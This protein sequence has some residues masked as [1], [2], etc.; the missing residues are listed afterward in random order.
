MEAA[1]P[2]P[3]RPQASCRRRVATSR[4]AFACVEPFAECKDVKYIDPGERATGRRGSSPSVTRF[5]RDSLPILDHSAT[6]ETGAP[7]AS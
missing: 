1:T 3:E 4:Q 6:P 2:S 7:L 5:A